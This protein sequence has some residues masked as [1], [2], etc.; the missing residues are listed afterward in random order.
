MYD[1][2]AEKRKMGWSSDDRAAAFGLVAR[3][4]GVFLAIYGLIY[5]FT[6]LA[7]FVDAFVFTVLIRMHVTNAP[8]S[9]VCSPFI[10]FTVGPLALL[11]GLV[12]LKRADSLVKFTY[13]REA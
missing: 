1:I 8:P 5:L 3:A 13:G 4:L 10:Y 12:L 9:C 6:G 11:T 7:I 2:V